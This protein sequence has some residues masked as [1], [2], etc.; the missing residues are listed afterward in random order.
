MGRLATDQSQQGRGLG[1]L[2]IGLAVSRCLEA[3][4]QV[5]AFALIVD[6][7]NDRA[8]VFYRHYGFTP[9]IHSPMTLY[10]PLGW[11][12][13]RCECDFEANNQAKR[14]VIGRVSYVAPKFAMW[15]FAN[16]EQPK[17]KLIETFS[18]RDSVGQFWDTD[19]NI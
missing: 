8:K 14:A 7:K 4:K 12:L 16:M 1:K 15:Q 11:P 19:I 2:L 3:R 9:C 10:L 6:A 5:A 13:F 18:R 17:I